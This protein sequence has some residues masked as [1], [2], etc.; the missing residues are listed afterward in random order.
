MK[1]S[2]WLKWKIGFVGAIGLT[3]LFQEVRTSAAFE[4]AFRNADNNQPTDTVVQ[5]DPVMDEF[6]ASVEEQDIQID[7]QEI[8]SSQSESSTIPSNRRSHTKT[9]RS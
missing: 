9:G 5:Q 7:Q 2:K 4:K 1:K 8:Q 3:I 6:I